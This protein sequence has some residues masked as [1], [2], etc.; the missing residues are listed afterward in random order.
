M[1]GWGFEVWDLVHTSSQARGHIVQ[2]VNIFC[3]CTHIS[4]I[5]VN[6]GVVW[7][8]HK[9]YVWMQKGYL[10]IHRGCRRAS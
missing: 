7:G 2:H 8:L 9:G 1:G 5:H 6:A 10:G 4:S 3:I